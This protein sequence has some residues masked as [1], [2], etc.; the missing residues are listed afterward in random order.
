M[1]ATRTKD[2]TAISEIT[3]LWRRSLISWPDGRSDTTTAVRWMQTPSLFVDLRQPANRPSFDGVR[4]LR[5]LGRA[6][7]EWLALQEGFA[8]EIRWDGHYVEWQRQFDFQPKAPLPDAGKLWFDGDVMMEEGRDIPYIEHWHREAVSPHPCVGIAL[9]DASTG[10]PGMLVR[11]GNLFMYARGRMIDP[12]P[13]SD[14]RQL[15]SSAPARHDM[16]D[17]IDCEISFGS[18]GAEGWQIEHSSLPFKERQL[19]QPKPVELEGAV[20][21]THDLG[22]DGD[23]MERRWDIT[24]VQGALAELFAT[25]RD[26]HD[27]VDQDDLSPGLLRP[28]RS[29]GSGR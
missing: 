21:R 24:R 13:Q 26:F 17:L 27:E 5:N 8:G 25:G 2:V 20:L 15:I 12:P 1:I 22:S 4:C 6:H 29:P 7:I 28:L 16:Q 23:C 11:A 9:R 19:L 10:Q 14:L 18:I 3:G